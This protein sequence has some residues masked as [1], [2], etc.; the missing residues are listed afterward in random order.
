MQEK[1]NSTTKWKTKFWEREKKKRG[2]T[3]CVWKTMYR[4]RER[5]L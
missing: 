5:E 1:T 4:M 2:I 3:F